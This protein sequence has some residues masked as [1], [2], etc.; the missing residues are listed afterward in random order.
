MKPIPQ[1]SVIIPAFNAGK[2]LARALESVLAQEGCTY[3]ILIVDNNST[4]DTVA[5]A[6]NFVDRYPDKVKLLSEQ[7]PGPSAARNRG[8]REA[9]A[10]WVQFLDADDVLLS[11]KLA[12]QLKLVRPTTNWVIGAIQLQA[13]N[14]LLATAT[15]VADHWFGLLTYTGMG[16]LNTNLFRTSKIREIAGF[17][18]SYRTCEDF[19]LFFRML[20]L[21]PAPLID[22]VAGA[23][24]LNHTGPRATNTRQK[25]MAELRLALTG[26]VVQHLRS[27]EPT[28]Y[29]Q[30]EKTINA[31]ILNCIRQ[32]MTVDFNQ[33]VE[34]FNQLFTEGFQSSIFQRGL[35]PGHGVLYPL[36]GF[37]RTEY[38]RL[39]FT[40]IMP[41]Q[42]TS[43]LKE[44]VKT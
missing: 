1:I 18:E 25:E 20:L 30:H 29:A 16:H 19:D 10:E 4:D 43:W 23:V 36:L 26:R 5:V 14:G 7:Q 38:L 6:T 42:W 13:E 15:P 34:T 37:V 9:G 12:R 44:L 3:E 41:S 28:Y 40:R 21:D 35:L 32:Q 17:L 31:A 33:G 27:A 24:H 8:L 22:E 39:Q 2:F 11:G